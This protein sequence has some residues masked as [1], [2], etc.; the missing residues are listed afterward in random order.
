MKRILHISK[1][2]YPYVG[3]TEVVCQDIAEGLSSDFENKV[4]CFNTCNRDEI[5]Y[6]NGIEIIRCAA[7]IKIASQSISL[8]YYKHLKH[9]IKNWKPDAI[10][11]HLPNPYVTFL[12]LRLIPK[13]TKLVLH[14]HLDIFKQR[15]I[16]FFI[17]GSEHKL[18]QRADKI[19]VTSKKYRDGSKPLKEFVN[20]TY[21]IDNGINTQRLSIKEGDQNRVDEIRHLYSNNPIIF[22]V[23]RHVPY[24]GLKYLIEAESYIKN[25]CHIVIAGNGPLTEELKRISNPK[26]V[27]F[28]GKL[29]EQD[30]RCYLHASY[31][32]AFPSI[33]KNEAFGLALAEGMYCNSVPVTFTIEGSGVN[34]VS[35]NGVTG[36]EVPNSNAVAY[37][38]AI[39]TLINDKNLHS[40][41]AKRGHERVT[42][43][44]T[45]EKEKENTRVLYKTEVFK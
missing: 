21:V 8:T 44:F 34:Y 39:D 3:G 36:I 2:Y 43:L 20:K 25:D 24:K 22:F 6:V 1:Y 38:N 37:A 33:T 45:I 15:L 28:V 35:L 31:I 5:D 11:F 14:W 40:T 32:F 29:S 10:H 12:L 4:I 27:H 17:K 9:I 41:Y 19:I 26:R 7:P 42:A 30:L 16:Y 18:L 13:T 23:G